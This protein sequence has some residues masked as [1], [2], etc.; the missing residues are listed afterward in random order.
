MRKTYGG[1]A[2][3]VSFD[4]ARCIHVAGCLRGLPEVF[5]VEERPWIQPDA[6]DPDAVAEVVARCPSG[7]LQYRRLDGGPQESH[8]V[9]R[10][11]PTLNGPLLVEGEIRV[12]RENGTEEV[13]PRATLCRCGAS[14]R[15][16]FCDNTH[17]AIGFVA[18]G[19][20]LR[21]HVS[22]VRPNLMEPVRAADDP[23]READADLD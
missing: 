12:L 9:T 22:A 5:D 8:S 4:L 20:P 13:L 3:E 23:R 7:A 17:L 16:P 6:A 19:E 2:I 11:T 21:V 14:A 18:P 1:T 10:V 15:K